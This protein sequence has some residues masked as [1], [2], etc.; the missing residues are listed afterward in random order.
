M[1][2][3][4]TLFP[5]RAM[6]SHCAL[7]Q[8]QGL[9]RRQAPQV[10]PWIAQNAAGQECAAKGEPM[11]LISSC[12]PEANGRKPQVGDVAWTL[13]LTLENGEPLELHVG[14]KGRDTLFGMMI[15][16]CQDSGEPEPLVAECD[17]VKK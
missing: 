15:A 6:Q 11:K 13:R 9:Q 17:R 2:R 12:H 14:N 10:L 3:L 16:D 7:P 1:P 5:G 8:N 4:R